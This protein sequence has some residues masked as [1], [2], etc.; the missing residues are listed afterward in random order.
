MKE[1]EK[2]E[3]EGEKRKRRDDNMT[4]PQERVSGVNYHKIKKRTMEAE[5]CSKTCLTFSVHHLKMCWM[6]IFLLL[7]CSQEKRSRELGTV[8]K[9]W[10]KM[11]A[12]DRKLDLQSL[13]NFM[14]VLPCWTGNMTD[15]FGRRL[16]HTSNIFTGVITSI[17][18]SI[19]Y[20]C[21]LCAFFITTSWGDIISWDFQ[22]DGCG[23][24]FFFFF[25][26]FICFCLFGNRGQTQSRTV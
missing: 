21:F 18:Q 5:G 22:C 4:K 2:K 23:R 17:Q 3:E 14:A 20:V 13:D 10:R 25:F 11:A 8:G 26:F 9:M 24:G 12:Q 7:K 19:L 15:G 16:T 6:N 1:T